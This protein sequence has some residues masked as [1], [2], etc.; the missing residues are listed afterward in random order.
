MR[1]T[2]AFLI[3]P[4]LLAG[5]LSSNAFAGGSAV[6]LPTQVREYSHDGLR[7]VSLEPVDVGQMP[8]LQGS[9]SL[10]V[11][12]LYVGPAEAPGGEHTLALVLRSVNA[13]GYPILTGGSDLLLE[14]DGTYV[15]SN[16]RAGGHTYEV[17]SSK[18]GVTETVMVPLDPAMMSVVAEA[19][20]VRGRLGPWFSFVLP[21]SHRSALT[22]ILDRIPSG[23]RYHLSAPTAN[24]TA[25]E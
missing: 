4:F 10:Y 14:V 6:P 23:A 20:V 13:D 5:C 1:P 25:S 18:G 11:G 9:V 22:G 8:T 16:P 2:F 19:D 3:T 21:P 17:E 7:F 15:A 12:A 24:F